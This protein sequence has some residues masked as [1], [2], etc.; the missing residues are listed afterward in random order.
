[1]CFIRKEKYMSGISSQG[2][3]ASENE[4]S[5]VDTFVESP[6]PASEP[7]AAPA[8]T[9]IL[10]TMPAGGLAHLARLLYPNDIDNQETM[11]KHVQDLFLLNQDSL[12]TPDVYQAGQSVRIK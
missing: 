7:V 1:M 12:R 5:P 2:Q 4:V 10:V 3:P 6:A 11:D 8:E 9:P